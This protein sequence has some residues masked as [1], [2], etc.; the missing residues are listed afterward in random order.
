V[1]VAAGGAVT[2][3]ATASLTVTVAEPLVV[4]APFA[5]VIEVTV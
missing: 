4:P 1:T 5:S 2:V 3:G